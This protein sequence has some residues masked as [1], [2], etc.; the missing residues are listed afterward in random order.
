MSITAGAKNTAYIA[1]NSSY[2]YSL[3]LCIHTR[4]YHPPARATIANTWPHYLVS[5]KLCEDR[6]GGGDCDRPDMGTASFDE[7][8]AYT[9][10]HCGKTGAGMNRLSFFFGLCALLNVRGFRLVVM[11]TSDVVAREHIAKKTGDSQNRTPKRT[12]R[13][14]V[15]GWVSCLKRNG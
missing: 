15:S 5:R 10:Q 4:G 8:V 3:P 2:R 14:D 7:K 12:S 6:S 1:I 9:T 13:N 11:D